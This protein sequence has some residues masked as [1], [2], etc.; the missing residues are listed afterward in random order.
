MVYE[1][2]GDYIDGLE[3]DFWKIL[4]YFGRDSVET[5]AKR[6]PYLLD[7]PGTIYPMVPGSY[8]QL[9]HEKQSPGLQLKL[10]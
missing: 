10:S 4:E 9:E 5:R 3:E 8:H 2:Y 7:H 1:V 6:P